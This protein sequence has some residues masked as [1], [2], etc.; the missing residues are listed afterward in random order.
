[1]S[2]RLAS[3]WRYCRSPRQRARRAGRSRPPSPRPEPFPARLLLITGE[4]PANPA[5]AARVLSS[6]GIIKVPER[7]GASPLPNQSCAFQVWAPNATR[8]EV[9]VG[10]SGRFEPLHAIGGGYYRGHIGQVEIG[11]PYLFRLN[12]VLERPDPASRQQSGGVHGPSRVC[13]LAYDWQDAAWRGVPLRRYVI[14]ELHV[15]TFSR[16][17]TFDGV[18]AQ[19]DRLRELGVTA[20]ELM[21]VAQFPG[22]RNWGY[23]GVYPFAVQQ[24]YGGPRALQRLVDACHRVG[25]AVVLDVVYNHLGPEGNYLGDFGPYFTDQYR[26]PWGSALNFDGAQNEGVR[27]YFLENALQWIEDFHVDALRLDAIHAIVDRSAHPFLEELADLVHRRGEELGRHLYV[28]G[29]S[30]LNDPRVVRPS[31]L[32]GHGLDAMWCDDFHHSAHSLITG[33]T[34]GYY[35]DFGQVD[36]LA[37]AFASGMSNAGAY[38]RFRQRRHGRPGTDLQPE[39]LV[40]CLQNHDQVGNRLLGERSAALMSFEQQKLAAGIVCLSRF[41]PLLFMGEEYGETAPFQY[42]VDHSDESLIAAI[43]KGRAQE[44]GH[45]GW[46]EQPPDPAASETHE[47]CVLNHELRL[48]GRHQVLYRL[49]QTLLRLRPGL[50]GALPDQCVPF[51]AQRIL[52][53]RRDCAWLAYSFSPEPQEVR[54]PIPLGGWQLLL[55]SA[56]PRWQGPGG[57]AFSRIESAGE[58]S[59]RLPPYSFICCGL[60]RGEASGVDSAAR[61]APASSVN[62]GM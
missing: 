42:F 61:G 23:D 50:L 3:S 11:S 22:S 33:E 34:S 39:Q 8:V 48:S 2:G 6:E 40:V 29:E 18:I 49:Y 9:K 13:D 27:R 20:I 25:L 4:P 24:S 38:S 41:V 32:G 59:L 52:L 60:D 57:P 19:I 44:F 55:S 36:Q 28:I 47:R 37:Q 62:A 5:G 46:R 31:A 12:G 45:F 54:L 7:L 15:G 14:Y 53:V 17:G 51:E 10:S 56:D 21:P 43:R 30:D 58:V 16:L 35:A 1:M 26:T